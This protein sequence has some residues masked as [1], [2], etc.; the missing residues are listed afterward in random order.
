MWEIPLKDSAMSAEGD[1]TAPLEDI[2][3]TDGDKMQTEAEFAGRDGETGSESSDRPGTDVVENAGGTTEPHSPPGDPRTNLVATASSE[4][5]SG[6]AQGLSATTKT[7]LHLAGPDEDALMPEGDPAQPDSSHIEIRLQGD[8]SNSHGVSEIQPTSEVGVPDRR[9]LNLEVSCKEPSKEPASPADKEKVYTVLY[10]CNK[11][12]FCT[13]KLS[14]LKLHA[15]SEQ[16]ENGLGKD[17]DASSGHEPGEDQALKIQ[18]ACSSCSFK[19]E[20]YHAYREHLLTH[21]KISAKEL[22]KCTDC[23]YTTRHK[24]NLKTHLKRHAKLGELAEEELFRCDQCDYVSP[25]KHDLMT[26]RKKHDP[27]K[28][29][30]CDQCDFQSIYKHSLIHHVRSKHERLRP[31]KCD[32]CDYSSARKQDLQTHMGRHAAEKRFKCDRC[33]YAT[34]YRVSFKAH[35]DRHMG[36]KLFKCEQEGCDFATTTKQNLKSHELRHSTVKPLKCAFCDYTA[37]HK[38]QMI[39]HEQKH[40]VMDPPTKTYSCL[41]CDYKTAHRYSLQ[42]HMNRHRAD[43][44]MPAKDYVCEECGYCTGYKNSLKRHMAKHSDVKPFKCGHCNYS[45][46]NMTQMH[47]HIAKHTGIKPFKCEV[48]DYATANKQHLVGHMAKHSSVRLNCPHCSF[49]TAWKQRLRAHLKAHETGQLFQ[50]RVFS[51]TAVQTGKILYTLPEPSQDQGDDVAMRNHAL[52]EISNAI[53][54]FHSYSLQVE[55]ASNQDQVKGNGVSPSGGQDQ[56][57]SCQEADSGSQRSVEQVQLVDEDGNRVSAA[58]QCVNGEQAI[59]VL[60]DGGVKS[61]V[62]LK[63]LQK[64]GSQVLVWG[65]DGKSAGQPQT[66][67]ETRQ[68]SGTEAESDVA[69]LVIDEMQTV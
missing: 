8:P 43:R 10:S 36:N 48:C 55:V 28:P 62:A 2:F 12:S 57:S 13:S 61:T 44:Q 35:M 50:K 54:A 14:E 15:Q 66:S 32:Q 67:S 47:V 30:R 59:E 17:D 65:Q 31:F 38:Q 37:A 11:C 5:S 26:H 58:L 45:A 18:Y 9:I 39:N 69:L 27:E 7:G 23:D 25:Y 6:V 33:S 24:Y 56:D 42:R 34:P 53:E 64:D 22:F 21:T 68:E 19:T 60:V 4:S 3:M 49:S 1:D 46:I 20:R 41:S 52:N 51:S 29:F 40:G 16:H 63:D